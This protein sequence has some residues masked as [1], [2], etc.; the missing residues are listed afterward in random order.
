MMSIIQV[1]FHLTT[2]LAGRTLRKLG[3]DIYETMEYTSPIYRIEM[4]LA[5]R[6]FAQ[7][8]ELYAAITQMNPNTG[9]IFSEF[10]ESLEVYE[11]FYRSHNLEGIHRRFQA[12]RQAPGGFLLG[13]IRRKFGPSGFFS[14]TGEQKEDRG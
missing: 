3:I 7:S 12:K 8:P 4:N 2:M 9:R 11:N 6:I 13:R 10:K 5:G 1:L 14:R